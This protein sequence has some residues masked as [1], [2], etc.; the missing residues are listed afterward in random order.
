M[1]IKNTISF[2]LLSLGLLFV[3]INEVFAQQEAQYTQYMYNPMSINP[4]YVGSR[5]SMNIQSLYRTQWVGLDGAPQTLNFGI[6]SP[7][8]MSAVGVGL[9]FTSEKI[10]PSSQSVIDANFSYTI[11]INT[12]VLLSFGVKAGVSLLSVDPNK[13]LIRDPGDHN[14]ELKDY[15]AP[16]IGTGLYLYS[17]DWYIGLSTPNILE[18]KYYN[19]VQVSTAIK[20]SHAYL[21]G[22][23]IFTINPNLQLK[24]AFMTKYVAGAPISLD[25]S[26][27]AL[28]Q[29][30]LILGLGYR[31]DASIS[32]LAG[33][34]IN[35]NIL[36]GYAYDYETADISRYSSG[37]HEIFLRFE[38]KTRQCPIVRTRFY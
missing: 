28:I 10:G 30:K 5:N 29:E 8:A 27:N 23:Y 11:P 15:H 6:H 24:P 26:A 12:D 37:S 4:A 9:G 19:D 2:I 16:I 1:N 14:L 35:E 20:K 25:L 38:L 13:L 17:E 3:S 22:G 18:T 31:L 36:I 21:M 32:G 7:I 33:F 34:Q